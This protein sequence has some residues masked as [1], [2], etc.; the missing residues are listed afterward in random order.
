VG[1]FVNVTVVYFALWKAKFRI[2]PSCTTSLT[3]D[4]SKSLFTADVC[5]LVDI[6]ECTICQMYMWYVFA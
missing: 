1:V 5:M 2:V 3:F 6:K 4:T